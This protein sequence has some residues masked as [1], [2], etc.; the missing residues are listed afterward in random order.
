MP[1]RL[2]VE[3]LS[4]RSDRRVALALLT[5]SASVGVAL[6][7]APAA[8]AA[9]PLAASPRTAHVSKAALYRMARRHPDRTIRAAVTLKHRAGP[10]GRA[11]PV[12][13]RGQVEVIGS[14]DGGRAAITAGYTQRDERGLARGFYSAQR[15]EIAAAVAQLEKNLPSAKGSRRRGIRRSLADARAFLRALRSGRPVIAGLRGSFRVRD[16]AAARRTGAISSVRRVT[17][18]PVRSRKPP[19]ARA[20]QGGGVMPSHFMPRVWDASTILTGTTLDG[21]LIP[22]PP[23]GPNGVLSEKR[24]WIGA[25][26]DTPSSLSWY[27]GA[28]PGQRGIEFEGYP[29][30]ESELWSDDW[31]EADDYGDTWASNLPSAYRDDL[32]GDSLPKFAI[33]SANGAE[34]E[35]NTYYWAQY[36]TNRGQTD[37]GSVHLRASAVRRPYVDEIWN[38]EYCL[39]LGGLDD[40]SCFFTEGSGIHIADYR[41]GEQ[42]E[43]PI[44]GAGYWEQYP[45]AAG[46]VFT[47]GM[48]PACCDIGQADES[49][50]TNSV[51]YMSIQ[52]G[53]TPA[54]QALGPDGH[55]IVFADWSGNL[56]TFDRDTRFRQLIYDSPENQITDP[57]WSSDGQQ[58]IFQSGYNIKAINANGTNL[59]TL[60]PWKGTQLSADFSPNGREIAFD[61]VTDSKGRSVGDY[62]IFV[63]TTTGTN[64]RQVTVNN[65]ILTG[66]EDPVWSPDGK[67]IAFAC[68]AK[69]RAAMGGTEICIINSDGT[70]IR[71]LTW[72]P[73]TSGTNHEPSWSPDGK[74]I[75]YGTTRNFQDW[76]LEVIEVSTG[77]LVNSALGVQGGVRP[78]NPTYRRAAPIP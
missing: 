52:E 2:R 25:V 6:T 55:T 3:A 77:K 36:Q 37:S 51:I 8:G 10:A 32:F 19:K 58:I 69:S 56:Y 66:G 39:T 18:K 23:P 73:P 72:L 4:V 12:T 13:S 11:L 5:A 45:Y 42:G 64:P 53:P 49:A 9:G 71:Q 63:S 21:H 60:I 67:Q 30:S 48:Y 40:A 68:H 38:I 17:R 50:L 76:T 65:A 7:L 15:R 14:F 31:S 26:W 78:V 35:L 61:S 22:T 33:G 70:G 24:T 54:F 47:F 1:D 57:R 59:R 20:S 46:D 44:G 16:L 29:A 41:T 34:V 75:V 27:Q 43:Y 74:R 28:E 62:H